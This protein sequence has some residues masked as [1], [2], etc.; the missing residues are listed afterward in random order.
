[1]SMF[2]VFVIH[3]YRQVVN[4]Y[5]I[6]IRCVHMTNFGVFALKKAYFRCFSIWPEL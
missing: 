5:M 4:E 6:R 2:A 3:R 1:M